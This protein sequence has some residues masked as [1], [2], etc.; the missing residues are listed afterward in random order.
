MASF[1]VQKRIKEIGIRKV[2]GAPVLSLIF[3]LIKDL[4]KWVFIASFLAWPAT[5][6]AMVLWLQSYAYRTE[7]HLWPF[8][9]STGIGLVTAFC[10]VVI[11]TVKASL[12]NPVDVLKYE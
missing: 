2:L 6:Y 12:A 7:V 1:T 5:Y 11:Q 10:T 9:L 8:L 3:S 4:T